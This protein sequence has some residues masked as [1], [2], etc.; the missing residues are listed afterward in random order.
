MVDI[1][2]PATTNWVPIWNPLTEGPVGP[3][4]PTGPTV[5]KVQ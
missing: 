5:Q 3:A 4:G 2:D 1:P